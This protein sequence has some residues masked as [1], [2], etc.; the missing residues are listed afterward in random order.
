MGA[1]QATSPPQAALEAEKKSAPGVISRAKIMYTAILAAIA[2]FT[3]PPIAMAAFLLL[4]QAADTAQTVK[5]TTGAKGS[6]AARSTKITPLWNAMHLL[7]VYVQ[8]MVDVLDHAGGVDLINQA[9]LVVGGVGAH[10]KPL[11]VA[12]LDT[13]ALIVHL[14]LNAKAFIGVTHK[15]VVFYWQMS[16][17]GGKTWTSL[18]STGYAETQ[19]ASPGPGTYQFRAS[20]MVGKTVVDWTPPFPLTIH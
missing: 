10:V 1:S 2:T 4:I 18:P 12:K 5:S 19:L 15:R 17:D 20:A 8:W 9:G 16:S 3:S 11:F 6:A 7:R 14:V 13:V